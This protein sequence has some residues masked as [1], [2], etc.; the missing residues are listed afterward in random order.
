VDSF[1]DL[2]RKLAAVAPKLEQNLARAAR[3]AAEAAATRAKQVHEYEDR[4]GVLTNSI[5]AEGPT[6]SFAAGD[7]TAVVSA[8]APYASYLEEGTPPHKIRPKFR[9]ALRWAVE[10]GFAFAGEVD[11][12]GTQPTRFL[13]NAVEA[14][15]PHLANNLVPQAIELSFVQAGFLAG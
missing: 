12:P 2:Q 10:G 11:H 15:E 6:G 13:A 3:M 14:T 4:S 5:G 1:S 8:G 9:K 7:L